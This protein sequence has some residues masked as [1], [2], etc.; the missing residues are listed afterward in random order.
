MNESKLICGQ[1]AAARRD[2][3]DLLENVSRYTK[4][5]DGVFHM[6]MAGDRMVT[7]EHWGKPNSK[8]PWL[9]WKVNTLLGRNSTFHSPTYS[10]WIPTGF[11]EFFQKGIFTHFFNSLP[12]GLLL[13]S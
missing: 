12:T 4:G 13:D 5:Q 9:L 11:Q 8:S 7:N 1:V 10:Y 6:K 3:S 2:D